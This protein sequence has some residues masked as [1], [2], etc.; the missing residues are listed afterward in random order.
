[1]FHF[2]A[3]SVNF[4]EDTTAHC[5]YHDVLHVQ[6]GAPDG[7]TIAPRL[8]K[9]IV[10]APGEAPRREHRGCRPTCAP[11]SRPAP[12]PAPSGARIPQR[13][14]VLRVHQAWVPWTHG[15]GPASVSRVVKDVKSA[16]QKIDRATV[17]PQDAAGFSINHASRLCTGRRR[18]TGGSPDLHRAELLGH[19]DV[20]EPMVRA[21]E[22]D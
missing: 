18:K 20:A 13:I 22:G 1:M 12:R 15:Y 17:Q 10:H 4:A 8:T 5:S 14:W 3:A 6:D 11:C 19:R 2:C 21:N 7:A 9:P 16:L